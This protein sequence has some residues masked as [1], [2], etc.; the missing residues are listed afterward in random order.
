MIDFKIKGNAYYNLKT[1]TG[2][3]GGSAEPGI[4]FVSK[5][6]NGNGEPDDEWYELAGSE[7]GK[8]TE[9]RG[10]EIT[11]Y[12]P[13]PAN[14]NVSWK[15]NQGNEG[16]ILRNSFH[17]QESYYPVWIQEN[18]ITFRGTRL[19]DNAVPENGL[20]V[21]YCYP[22]G[23]AD[24]H[25]ND[26]E[27]SNFKID[28]A[29]DSNGESIVLDCIDFVK[30]MTAVNQDAGQMGEISTEVTTVENLHFKN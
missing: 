11:Y 8:D 26:K 10:Y 2:K 1:E 3:L 29:I 23:Y 21:G 15:D 27:G 4:V 7:Y 20:W 6:V 25:R 13:E 17:N 18:E 22:W 12:R 9:T 19:K 28:W 24:N 30:I 14:Q 5:D 16:E